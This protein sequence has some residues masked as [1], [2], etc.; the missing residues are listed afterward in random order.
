MAYEENPVRLRGFVDLHTHTT[1]S[2]GTLAPEELVRHAAEMG[3]EAIAVT[4]HDTFTGF[5][6]AAA[7]ARGTSLRVVRGIE[8]NSRLNLLAGGYRS[9]HI[10]G[11]FPSEEPLRQF[12]EWLE[13]QRRERRTRNEKLVASLRARNVDIN[14]AE[15]EARGK[16][17]AGRVH[18]ARVLVEKGYAASVEDAFHRF[19]GESAPSFV[20]RQSYTSE[21]TVRMIRSGG[22]IPVVAH[23]IR[24]ALDRQTER[25][26]FERLRAAGLAGLEIYHSEHPPQAQ[27]HYRQLAEELD[28]IPTGG[29]DFHGAVK[30]G[31]ELGRG[32]KDNLRVPR[33]FLDRLLSRAVPEAQYDPERR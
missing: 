20:E 4:D 1:E 31:T 10:L 33:E 16:A 18:F 24:L 22:G 17:L 13:E 30:P 8:L 25:R 29:S 26:V 21:Q 9:A 19:L 12:T 2:D 3:L 6:Q 32:V 23:P 27:A 11:Y 7:K 15:I 14:L 28:L 5:E